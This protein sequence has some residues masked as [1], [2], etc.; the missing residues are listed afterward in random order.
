MNVE[1]MLARANVHL[2]PEDV[3]RLTRNLE[4]YE[5]QLAELRFP[6]ARYLEPAVI[7][8]PTR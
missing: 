6:E 4:F 2:A 5:A 7:H 8:I 3:E 1:D